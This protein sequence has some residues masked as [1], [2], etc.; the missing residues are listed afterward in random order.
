MRKIKNVEDALILF[1]THVNTIHEC[2][3]SG[4]YRKS[5]RAYSHVETI[6]KYLLENH[7]LESLKTFYESSNL[8]LRLYAATYLAPVDSETCYMIIKEIM[9]K[10]EGWASFEAEYTLK[11]WSKL[12]NPK[13]YDRILAK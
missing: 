12:S 8:F 5:N 7:A 9:D 2:S 10:D 11:D 13:V 1:E 6:V 3:K 4:N